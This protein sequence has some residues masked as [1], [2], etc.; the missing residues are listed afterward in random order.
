[1]H[2]P[3]HRHAFVKP[4]RAAR[5]PNVATWHG[6]E[7]VDEYAWLRADNWQEV[8]RDPAVLDPEIR[9]YLEAENAYIEAALADTR[10]LQDDAVRR[11]EG[12]HQGGR[13]LGA[14]RPTAPSTT[15]SS[16]VAGGQY[17]RLAAGARAAAAET[18]LLD[19]NDEAEGKPYW[20]LGGFH[21]Q[22]RSPLLAYAVDDK[23]S[24]LY[25]IRIRDL[26]TGQRPARQHPRHARRHRLGERQQDVCSTC[27]STSNHRP[28]L[29]YRHVV[30]TPVEDDVLVYEEKDIGFYVGVG[31]DPVGQVRRSSTRTTI[32][33]ARL[34]D[35]CRS[36]RSTRRASSS[37][38]S[39]GH[40]YSV[41]HHGDKL[42]ITTNSGGAEDFRICRGAGRGPRHGELAR[43]HSAPAR[44]A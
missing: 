29:V 25:T 30:G 39:I 3:A 14:R 4:P 1:M 18:V 2:G 12:A 40:E 5:R 17:P 23:G 38:A 42:I 27:A 21:A 9:A 8:M 32:R 24:E 10:A 15:T 20:Q 41:E 7:L 16:Y 19:G 22:P 43:D 13:Q 28:L 31:H 36:R 11:D 33:P 26:A 6:V 44:A 34:P 37:R 35:R